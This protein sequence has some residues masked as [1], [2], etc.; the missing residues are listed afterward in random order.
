MTGLTDDDISRLIAGLILTQNMVSSGAT[1]TAPTEQ[2]LRILAA[3]RDESDTRMLLDVAKQD[4][5]ILTKQR[6]EA[7]KWGQ[8]ELGAGDPDISI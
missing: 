6:D 3:L 7:R 2:M 5:S 8:G 1:P 4:I